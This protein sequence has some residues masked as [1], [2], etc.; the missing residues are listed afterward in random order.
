MR[1]RACVLV[2][3]G[4][5]LPLACAPSEHDSDGMQ[6][7][8]PDGG[9]GDGGSDGGGDGGDMQ[10]P[11]IGSNPDPSPDIAFTQ[12][13]RTVGILRSNEPASAGPFDASGTLAYGGWL[14]DL[15]G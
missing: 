5:V 8:A 3:I 7:P 15:D 4:L 14:A 9:S 10:D 12:V 2:S 13:A 11:G 1:A 6:A